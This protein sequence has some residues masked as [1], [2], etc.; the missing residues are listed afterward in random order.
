MRETKNIRIID[1]EG[2]KKLDVKLLNDI[3]KQK[4]I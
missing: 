1:W 2:V 3:I 4:L